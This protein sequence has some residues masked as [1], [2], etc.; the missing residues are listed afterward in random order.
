[1]LKT[2]IFLNICL[3]ADIKFRK[4][5]S[6][7]RKISFPSLFFIGILVSLFNIY[8]KFNF[9]QETGKILLTAFF[10][11]IG[12]RY[13]KKTFFKGFKWQMIFLISAVSVSVF[14]NLFIKIVGSFVCFKDIK[15]YSS[16]MLMG[17]F[18]V[19]S[20]YSS[21]PSISGMETLTIILGTISCSLFFLVISKG[22]KLYTEKLQ[23]T[24]IKNIFK[25][26]VIIFIITVLSLLLEKTYLSPLKSI[27]IA[28]I[29]GLLFR[30][31]L[32]KKAVYL[33]NFHINKIGN[34][35]L[36]LFILLKFSSLDIKSLQILA[37][38][39][40]FIVFLQIILLVLFS[41]FFVYKI[42][43]KKTLAVFLSAA[44]LGFSIGVP[45]STMSVL[46]QVGKERGT[47]PHMI[48]I[49]PVVG[50]W[51]ITYFNPV[52]SNFFLN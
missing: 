33:E 37:L 31:N 49:V 14:Q 28:Y 16:L 10:S 11:T 19:V 12:L 39:D 2:F 13:S 46:Q 26:A 32:D 41:A 51:L 17:D 24:S 29:S 44:I 3:L 18:S 15:L 36:S 42:Y 20:K 52:I 43:R 50:A 5:I 40:I 6:H 9:T 47:P 34:Y 27:G 23:K 35:F 45:P 30:W 1:M 48:M 21:H 4:E 25:P 7:L 8:F 38:S 22:K